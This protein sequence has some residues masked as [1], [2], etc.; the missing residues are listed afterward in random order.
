MIYSQK[1][2][3]VFVRIIIFRE[4]G[5]TL[6]DCELLHKRLLPVVEEGIPEGR[7]LSMEV[8]S[9]GIDRIFKS[10]REY[11][12]F[13]G[14]PVLLYGKGTGTPFSGTIDSADQS[15]FRLKLVDGSYKEFSYEEIQKA[16]LNY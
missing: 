5:F 6:R 14:K 13:R 8:T 7:E 11:S 9:P 1:N 12:I 10:D 2:R 3:N 15:T 4:D 16:K